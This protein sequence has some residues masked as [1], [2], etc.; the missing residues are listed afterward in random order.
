[1]IFSKL[2]PGRFVIRLEK[3]D[4]ILGSIR[5]FAGTN[6]IGAAMFE[7]IGSL[8]TAKLGHYDF[9]TKNY[10]YEI[11]REDLE[12]LSLSGNVSTLN[13]A[14]LPHAHVTLGRRDFSVIGGHLDEGSSANMVEIGL[15][16]LPGKL[17]KAKDDEV[18]LN[19]LQLRQRL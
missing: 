1:L 6:R 2:G 18:G 12:I 9:A 19:L 15:S 7:G 8:N 4:D 3:G 16:T 10:K 11:F 13:K 14:P 5:R 17:V